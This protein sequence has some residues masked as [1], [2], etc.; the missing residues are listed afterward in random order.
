MRINHSRLAAVRVLANPVAYRVLAT[1]GARGPQTT[2]GL[3][4]LLRGVPTSSLYRQLARLREAGV[5]QVTGERQARGAVER[6]YA[7]ASS[8][9]GGF[10]QHELA[11]VPVSHRRALLRNFLATLVA[12]TSRYIE[13]RALARSRPPMNAGLF[14][15]RLTESEYLD[16]AREVNAVLARSRATAAGG[17]DAERRNFYF[18]AIPEVADR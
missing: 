5:L 17:P 7:L 6:T 2:G 4:R 8:A 10:A 11:A 12:D 14:A 18:V 9:A 1:I 15:C 13:S 3:G 16:V